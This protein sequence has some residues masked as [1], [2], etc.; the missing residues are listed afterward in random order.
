LY[1]PPV[2]VSDDG[3]M[4]VIGQADACI[5]SK[6]HRHFFNRGSKSRNKVAVGEPAAGSFLDHPKIPYKNLGSLFFQRKACHPKQI[7]RSKE[8][9]RGKHKK[10]PPVRERCRLKNV[11]VF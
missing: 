4:Q 1:T 11:F 6:V 2:V 3:A 8:I 9:K 7:S 5:C 10:L